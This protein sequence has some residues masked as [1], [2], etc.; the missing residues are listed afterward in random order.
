MRPGS[1]ILGRT[2]ISG[3]KGAVACG[4]QTAAD[5]GVDI[6][7]QGGNAID[8][9]I[10]GAFASFVVEPQMCGIGGHG[11][12]SVYLSKTNRA[13][14]IDHF[15]RAP[16]AATPEMYTQALA[17]WRNAGWGG[18]EGAI[19]T[20]GHLSVGIPGTVAGLW[21]AHRLF[22]KLP[23]KSLVGPA[24]EL[25]RAAFGDLNVKAVDGVL[26]D[27]AGLIPALQ[28]KQFDVIAASMAIRPA[29]CQ[30]VLFSD[31]YSAQ[32]MLF[33]YRDNS[34]AKFTDFASIA[35]AGARFGGQAGAVE[36]TLAKQAGVKEV[37]EFPDLASLLDGMKA[38][39]AD[40]MVSIPIAVDDA[41]AALG[42]GFTKSPPYAPMVDGK[43]GV[44]FQAFA[45]RKE[46]VALRDAFNAEVK[47]LRDSGRLAQIFAPF[48][49]GPGD[50]ELGAKY[51]ADQLCKE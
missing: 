24:I 46:D 11:R 49:I 23:W 26:I 8:A 3:S 5:V 35:A 32:P 22:A 37:V 30:Q 9:A 50:I 29:R 36:V 17:R 51:T 41:F 27:F 20:T 4:H 16:K 18:V 39:R 42:P 12:M 7:R 43:P 25:A 13:V 48:K 6:I 2:P 10:A 28:A 34:T 1:V 45:F 38:R 15:I 14:G 31:P 47:K 44:N 40:V 21:E 19:N 33:V